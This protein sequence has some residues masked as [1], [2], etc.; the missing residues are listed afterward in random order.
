MVLF[1]T[2]QQDYV[3]NALNCQVL[4]TVPQCLEAM[5]MSPEPKIQEFVSRIRYVI[6]DE[7]HCI[8]ATKVNI[9]N[10]LVVKYLH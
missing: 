3:D 4:I 2:M 5:L 1:G 8:N 9:C 6:L 10:D 7:V